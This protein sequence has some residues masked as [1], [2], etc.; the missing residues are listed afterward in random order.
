M[1]LTI[2]PTDEADRSKLGHGRIWEGK[3][4]SGVPVRVLVAGLMPDTA[5]AR[6][7]RMFEREYD[8]LR[9]LEITVEDD[10]VMRSASVD[11]YQVIARWL[12]AYGD[13]AGFKLPPDKSPD[14]LAKELREHADDH[15]ND[16]LLVAAATEV[17]KYIV[18]LVLTAP[19]VAVSSEV[20]HA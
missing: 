13:K 8:A 1:K 17:T 6:L 19:P 7:R 3:T 11:L 15:P 10:V 16:R 2:T 5:D 9:E 20:G 14:A 18:D 12:I 4:G